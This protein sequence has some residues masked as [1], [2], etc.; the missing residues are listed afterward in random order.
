MV[1]FRKCKN[2][3]FIIFK[4]KH[5]NANANDYAGSL[6]LFLFFFDMNINQDICIMFQKNT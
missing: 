1:G 4:K 6:Q 3:D 5:N 2:Q